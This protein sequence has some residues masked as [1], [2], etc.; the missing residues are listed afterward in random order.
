MERLS[1]CAPSLG[2]Q[3]RDDWVIGTAPRNSGR[4]PRRIRGRESWEVVSALACAS[5]QLHDIR[6]SL[7]RNECP[8]PPKTRQ[9]GKNDCRSS[10]RTPSKGSSLSVIWQSSSTSPRLHPKSTRKSTVRAKVGF[11]KISQL[12]AWRPVPPCSPPQPISGPFPA[13]GGS[14]P[15]AATGAE[16]SREQPRLTEQAAFAIRSPLR[17]R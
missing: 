1:E 9:E 6:F 17:A 13:T 5:G 14:H 4:E 3:F 2:D 16:P 15:F 10:G 12:V 7:S 8:L 11:A